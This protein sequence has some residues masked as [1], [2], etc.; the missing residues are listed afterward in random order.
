M[1]LRVRRTYYVKRVICRGFAMTF[2]GYE[3]FPKEFNDVF[4]ALLSAILGYLLS[5]FS[6]AGKMKRE[7]AARNK[8]MAYALFLDVATII[9]NIKPLAAAYL[10]QINDLA[11][12][13]NVE[14]FTKI[15]PIAGNNSKEMSVSKEHLSLLIDTGHT[16]FINDIFELE[17]A[18]NELA[19]LSTQYC[20]FR[21][22]LLEEMASLAGES[23]L[24]EERSLSYEI[25]DATQQSLQPKIIALSTLTAHLIDIAETADSRATAVGETLGPLLRGIFSEGELKISLDIEPKAK[26]TPWHTRPIR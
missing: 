26:V 14:L 24:G 2:C 15:E 1:Y 11:P 22:P 9:N 16:E 6:G 8:T 17:R 25:S 10:D 23:E 19:A 13:P 5:E 3:I 4:T 18:Q 12:E 7:E 20:A 21:Q